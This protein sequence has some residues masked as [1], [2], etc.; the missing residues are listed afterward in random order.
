MSQNKKRKRRKDLGRPRSVHTRKLRKPFLFV[1]TRDEYCPRVHPRR[2]GSLRASALF[3]RRFRAL[4]CLEITCASPSSSPIQGSSP[5]PI[6]H[7][8]CVPRAAIALRRAPRSALFFSTAANV[9]HS[10]LELRTWKHH[11]RSSATG[12][13]AP[14]WDRSGC[15]WSIVSLLD[16]SVYRVSRFFS[17]SWRVTVLESSTERWVRE[18]F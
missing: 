8:R 14:L 4:R 11:L 17:C 16:L 2:K 9:Y 5:L 1:S 12:S 7:L 15:I 10:L 13:A 18:C 6:L 3:A